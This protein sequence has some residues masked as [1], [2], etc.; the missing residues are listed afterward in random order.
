MRLLVLRALGLGD[1]L[2]GLPALRGLR[3]AWPGAR[4]VLATGPAAGGL[5]RRAGVVD[6]VVPAGED[7][8][9]LA[10][11]GDG[12]VAV[13]LHGRGPR[14]HRLLL[15]TRPARLVAFAHPDVPGVPGPAWD[16][17][18]HEVRRWARLVP[19]YELD[20]A[21]L[22]LPPAQD[23]PAVEGAVVVH[24]GAAYAARRWPAERFAAVARAL[25][26]EGRRVVVTGSAPERPLAE[27]VARGL[28]PGAVLAG[29]LDLPG[30]VALLQSAALVV[31][32]DTGVG[33]LATACGAP[34]VHL[35]GPEPP[36]RWA[37]LVHPERHAVLWH[38]V[39]GV[40]TGGGG[41]AGV[42]DPLT[43]RITVD[44]VLAA[45]RRLLP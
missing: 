41:R 20:P 27:E 40:D 19:S 30:M 9:P 8:A 6:E 37:P 3:R 13:N 25:A 23:A 34:A 18:E 35:F 32:G 33:H 39:E 2:T 17:R 43:L 1:A 31:V 28:G 5:L 44:E 21:D 29:A 12:H 22:L 26:S 16:E 38:G 42:P 45:A 15:A 36:G 24:P 10:W 14:S 11:T 4:V 7:L